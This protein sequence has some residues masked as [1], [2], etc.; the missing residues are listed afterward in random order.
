MVGCGLHTGGDCSVG[1]HPGEPNSGVVFVT[2]FG[3]I[4]ARVEYVYE[5]RRGTSLRNGAAQVHT[6]E[7]LL[8]ALYGLNIDNALVEISG[9]ELPAGDGSALPF[10]E[11]IESAGTA[12]QG[13][14][15]VEI[16]LDELIRTDDTDR[17]LSASPRNSLFVEGSVVFAH[18]LIGEQSNYFEI[19]P[20]VFKREIAP[21]RTFC[22]SDEI[23]MIL[24]QGL[25]LGG[26][27]DNVIVVYADRYSVPLRY[28]DEFVRHKIL[29]VVGDLSLVG[30]RLNAGIKAVKSSH[31]LNVSLAE[32]IVRGRSSIL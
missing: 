8:S 3:E 26:N 22:T 9:P 18:R 19:T 7:H 5:T 24:S 12:G 31:A 14:P 16:Y 2:E 17:Y 29:D 6:V 10:V 1:L 30:G 32:R 28:P 11:L 27:D 23:D 25:G 21:A 20:E 15:A 13:E 4:P